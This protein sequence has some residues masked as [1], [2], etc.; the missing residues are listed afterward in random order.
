CA[1]SLPPLMV[2]L[3]V[4]GHPTTFD[5][6]LLRRLWIDP[7]IARTFFGIGIPAGV[8]MVMT[9]LSEVAVVSFVN[10]FGS[11]AT[12]AYGAVNQVAGYL[13]APMQAV[14]LVATVFAA[15]AVGARQADRLG[16]VTRIAIVLTVLIGASAVGAVYLF[17]Q[18]L[19]SWF[20]TDPVTLS[21]AGRALLITLWSYV[22]VGISNVLIGVMRSSGAVAWPAGIAIA[23]IWLVQLPTTYLLSRWIGLDGVWIGYPAGFI[24]ALIAQGIY[25]G[26]VWRHRPD[27]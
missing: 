3:R 13:L 17:S 24:V 14:G 19:L 4:K 5:R 21:I 27:Q 10:P 15:R 6:D 12:A 9:S 11:S 26:L 18:N 2:Y 23:A 25:Y 1:V 20:V 8:Q 7:T 16:A 22:F